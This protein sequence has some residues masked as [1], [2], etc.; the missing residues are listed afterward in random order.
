MSIPSPQQTIAQSPGDHL[1]WRKPFLIAATRASPFPSCNLVAENFQGS[2]Q[3]GGCDSHLRTAAKSGQHF[4]GWPRTKAQDQGVAKC[5]TCLRI[6]E[7]RITISLLEQ[8]GVIVY[9]T[10][11]VEMIP[12]EKLLFFI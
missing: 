8:R 3:G 12:I 2:L 10:M 4:T 11:Q 5:Y 7:N 1:R 9:Y 6:L